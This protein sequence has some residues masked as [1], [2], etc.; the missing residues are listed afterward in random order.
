MNGWEQLFGVLFA[1]NIFNERLK[2]CNTTHENGGF[3]A[4]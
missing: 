4:Y 2:S 3:T 1:R